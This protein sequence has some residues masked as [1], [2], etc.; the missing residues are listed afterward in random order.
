MCSAIVQ[1]AEAQLAMLYPRGLLEDL[2]SDA[3]DE[4]RVLPTIDNSLYGADEQRALATLAS[5]VAA[6]LNHIP[7]VKTKVPFLP[8]LI[9]FSELTV[10][11]EQQTACSGA[12]G[13]MV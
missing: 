9:C 3:V 10:M 11:L 8:S 6:A 7:G 1:V 13:T 2:D 5:Q 12:F 4:S